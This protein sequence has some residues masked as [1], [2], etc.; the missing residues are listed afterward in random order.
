MNQS[1]DLPAVRIPDTHSAEYKA[2]ERFKD[3]W[4]A[5]Y[6]AIIDGEH[7]AGV[8]R[9]YIVLAALKDGWFAHA[10]APSQTLNSATAQ[11][12]INQWQK[13]ANECEDTALDVPDVSSDTANRHRANVFR[14]CAKQLERTIS[15]MA[16][17]QLDTPQSDISVFAQNWI[18][19]NSDLFT[20]LTGQELIMAF[21]SALQMRPGTPKIIAVEE[22]SQKR[23]DEPYS[24]IAPLHEG[25]VWNTVLGSHWCDGGNPTRANAGLSK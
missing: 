17:T 21:A 11:Q 25:H 12:L 5:K 6:A 1:N 2:F 22:L 4:Y 15:A 16:E 7:E 20:Q 3:S 13:A 23:C 19:R 10:N 14:V 24:D 9:T 18:S 8:D